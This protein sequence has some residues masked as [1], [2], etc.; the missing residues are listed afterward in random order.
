MGEIRYHGEPPFHLPITQA[1]TVRGENQVIELTLFGNVAGMGPYDF[2][3]RLGLSASDAM[4]LMS[5]IRRAI[6]QALER[7]R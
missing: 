4:Q 2:P 6:I 7:S 3:I 5:D 1:P